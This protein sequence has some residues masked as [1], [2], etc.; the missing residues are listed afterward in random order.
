MPTTRS[1]TVQQGSMI[2]TNSNTST[3]NYSI[4]DD[5]DKLELL[6]ESDTFNEH[7]VSDWEFDGIAYLKDTDGFIYDIFTG[8][9]IGYFNGTN[10]LDVEENGVWVEQSTETE[11]ISKEEI[12][13]EYSETELLKIRVKQLELQVKSKDNDIDLHL[14]VL[15]NKDKFIKQDENIRLHLIENLDSINNKYINLTKKYSKIKEEYDTLND[16]EQTV[17][18]VLKESGAFLENDDTKM[19]TNSIMTYEQMSQELIRKENVIKRKDAKATRLIN[20]IRDKNLELLNVYNKLQEMSRYQGTL[21][22]NIKILSD[23]NMSWANYYYYN[24]AQQIPYTNDSSYQTYS[25][26]NINEQPS[27]TIDTCMTDMEGQYM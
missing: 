13:K 11:I 5:P 21:S 14:K 2:N 8:V 6:P 3:H 22:S 24:T 27:V 10:I 23:E 25:D 20:I 1:Q 17:S 12:Y 7:E 26:D 16:T 15:S 18:S 9:N 19:E 4:V